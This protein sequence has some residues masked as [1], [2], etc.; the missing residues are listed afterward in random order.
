MVQEATIDSDRL[1]WIVERHTRPRFELVTEH[2]RRLR[3]AGL[4]A[5]I[6]EVVLYYSLVGAA[7]LAYVNAPE[8]RLLGHDTL[9]DGP[10]SR[11]TPTPSSRCSSARPTRW[12]DERCRRD[13]GRR[14]PGRRH[15]TALLLA[16]RGFSVRVF[17]RAT[18]VYDLP[19]AIV[20][21]DEI[22]RV[23]QNAG[24]LDELRAITTPLRGAEFVRPDGERIIG[25][26]IPEDADWP[27]GHA[28][29]GHL[30]PARTGG[31]PAPRRR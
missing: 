22:Q 11:R 28:P 20:M 21:D 4:V 12:S 8:A 27:L 19:R 3:E 23:F 5:D 31:V 26:E 17:E 13:R 15:G 14:R 2:W 10:S 25:I 7:S 16:Q 30:L 6:D 9:T 18:E 24:L 29:L 1:H